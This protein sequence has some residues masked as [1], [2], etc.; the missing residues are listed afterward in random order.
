MFHSLVPVQ[1][2]GFLAKVNKTTVYG[3]KSQTDQPHTRCMFHFQLFTEHG[4][5]EEA[6]AYRNQEGHQQNVGGAGCRENPELEDV[7]QAG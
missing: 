7:G 5:A 6:S 3:G 4:D 2:R 1:K